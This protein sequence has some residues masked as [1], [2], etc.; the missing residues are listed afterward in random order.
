MHTENAISNNLIKKGLGM[1]NLI[2]NNTFE[3]IIILNLIKK[4]ENNDFYDVYSLII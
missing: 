1:K 3:K 2:N 4:I